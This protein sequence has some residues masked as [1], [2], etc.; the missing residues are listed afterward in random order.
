MRL[1]GHNTRKLK[2]EAQ[3]TKHKLSTQTRTSRN[4]NSN[5]KAQH[6][7]YTTHKTLVLEHKTQ[8]GTNVHSNLKGTKKR[9]KITKRESHAQNTNLSNANTPRHNTVTYE[10]HTKTAF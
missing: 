2:H 3:D 5:A 6:T 8:L 4:P 10:Q 9:N 7:P 1:I